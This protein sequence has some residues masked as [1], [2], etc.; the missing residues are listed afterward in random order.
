MEQQ[1]FKFGKPH[2]PLSPLGREL[3][4][5]LTD[6]RDRLR[7]GE[8]L[9][10]MGHVRRADDETQFL[11]KHPLKQPWQPMALPGAALPRPTTGFDECVE[12]LGGGLASTV[13]D[14]ERADGATDA[15][16]GS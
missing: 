13:G 16:A 3:V 12:S 8:R 1:K 4:A 14:P 11:D 7:A 15:T 10:E 9:E 5:G 6:L 2:A